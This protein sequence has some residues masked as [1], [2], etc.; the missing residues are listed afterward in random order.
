MRRAVVALLAL[1]SLAHAQVWEKVVVPGVNY[2]M[3]VQ[4]EP[5]RL[6]HVLRINPGAP[7]LKLVPEQAQGRVF[8]SNESKG[9]EGVSEMVSRTKAIAGFNADFFPFTGDPLG[10]MV[11][12]GELLS[13][14]YKNRPVFGWGDGVAKGAKLEWSGK[15]SAENG[16]EMPLDGLNQEVLEDQAVLFTSAAAAAIAKRPSAFL[17]LRVTDPQ[18][19]PNAEVSAT[20]L[21]VNSDADTLPINEGGAI[22]A[23]RGAKAELF[24]QFSPGTKVVLKWTTK[25]FDWT[26]VSNVVGG[27]PYLI[28]EGKGTIDWKAAGFGEKFATDRHPRTAIGRTREGD[29]VLVVVDGRQPMSVGASLEEMTK[30]MSDLGCDEAINLDGGGSSTF[31]VLGVNLNRPSD[32]TERKVANGVLLYGRTD[33]ATVEGLKISGPT[34]VVDGAPVNLRVLDSNGKPISNRHILWSA[35]GAGWVDQN[36]TV[37]AFQE[38][39]VTVTAFARGQVMTLQIPTKGKP[40]PVPANPPKG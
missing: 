21:A 35:M 13:T 23:A 36:G 34:E 31:N 25:G 7:A 2:R 37:R 32:G 4:W 30:I 5:A 27:G 11:R 9:R 10:A 8:T 12:E 39:Q 16:I 1:T 38:G 17:T 29:V 20:V 14:P 33:P 24:K 18:Y 26:K 40:A 6:I 3:Q 15:L 22:L 19:S 28:S